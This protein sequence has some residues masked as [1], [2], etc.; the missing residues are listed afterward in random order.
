MKLL[1]LLPSL[2]LILVLTGASSSPQLEKVDR[3]QRAHSVRMIAPAPAH[4][5]YQAKRGTE[6]SH[7]ARNYTFDELYRLQK[8]LLDAFIYPANRVQAESINSSFF[9]PDVQGR[10]DVT[11]TFEGPELNT[12]YIFGL[13]SNLALDQN[14]FTLLGFATSYEIVH[15]S[16]SQNIASASTRFNF[17]FPAL[18]GAAI[19]IVID[20]WN[21]FDDESR[22]SMYDATFKWWQ[23]TVDYLLE[24]AGKSLNM[25]TPQALSFAQKSLAESICDTAM[26]YCNGTNVQYNSTQSC[27]NFLTKEVRFGAAYELGRNTLLCRMVHQN[28]VP[29][30]PSTHCPHIGPSGGGYCDDDRSYIDTVTQNYFSNYPF[31]YTDKDT[32]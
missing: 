15:F 1:T 17:S 14:S 8:K 4:Q 22:I 23:W 25:T 16:A 5:S 30:R 12:E 21:V 2:A 26:R 29:F 10:V 31:V 28:M 19:P 3:P 32:V 9:S 13:F 18:G 11:R 27:T 6:T 7:Q 20:T 24:E